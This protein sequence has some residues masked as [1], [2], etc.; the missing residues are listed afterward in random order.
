MYFCCHLIMFMLFIVLLSGWSGD[1]EIC[2]PPVSENVY[3]C[4]FFTVNNMNERLVLV[5]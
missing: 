5:R 2:H 4:H 1:S 3:I